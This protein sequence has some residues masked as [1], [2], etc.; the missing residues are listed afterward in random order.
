MV[1]LRESQV[2]EIYFLFVQDSSIIYFTHRFDKTLDRSNL[3]KERF[4][5]AH[6]LIRDTVH[7]GRKASGESMKQLVIFHLQSECRKRRMQLLCLFLHIF[8]SYSVWGTPPPQFTEWSHPDSVKA[9]C[10]YSH[11]HSWRRK[12]YM[13]PNEVK[14]TVG[15]TIA[16]GY[17]TMQFCISHFTFF[18]KQHCILGNTK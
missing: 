2:I 16:T 15:I 4:V 9:L 10:K 14:L 12:S 3:R 6:D 8:L 13:I 5:C 11:R 17:I 18:S 1:L 7:H